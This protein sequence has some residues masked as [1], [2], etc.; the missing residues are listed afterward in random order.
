MRTKRR[1][2]LYALIPLLVLC[3]GAELA[4]RVAGFQYESFYDCPDW[5]TR[6]VQNP[7]FQGDPELF[8]KLKPMANSDLNPES[9]LTQLI[10]PSG[11]RDD[12]TPVEKKAQELRI[13]TLGDSCTFGDGVANWETYANVLETQIRMAFPDRKVNVL[14]AGVPGYTAYQIDLYL[15]SKLLEYKPDVVTIYVGFNDNIPA[16]R[17]LSDKDIQ[18]T[19][20]I[21]IQAIREI[22][23]KLRIY[24]FIEKSVADLKSQPTLLSPQK[25]VPNEEGVEL[26]FRVSPKDYM[27]T[28]CQINELGKREGF[29]VIVLALPHT[30]LKEPH[31]NR[32]IRIAARDCS[33]PMLDLWEVMKAEQAKGLELYNS[34]GGH[35]NSLGHRVIAESLFYKLQNI[36]V[37]PHVTAPKLPPIETDTIDPDE[38]PDE[39]AHN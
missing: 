32:N 7:V 11:F 13:I 15:R 12:I 9:R 6:C 1:R 5:W 26:A 28:L 20:S 29:K 27:E 16:V 39:A 19:N 36:G 23:D 2:W 24:Q 4:L 35:P 25:P 8:W 21:Y 17:G 10:N 3:F 37:L 18:K 38:F 14:N 34:D 30:F 22:A 33:I 31:R